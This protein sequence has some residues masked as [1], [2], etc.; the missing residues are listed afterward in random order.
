MHLVD[1]LSNTLVITVD[2]SRLEEVE[3]F[4]YLGARV[5]NNGDNGKEIRCR[6]AMGIKALNGMKKL[7]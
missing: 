3:H 2:G 5:E 1:F 4:Q 7:W 6:L